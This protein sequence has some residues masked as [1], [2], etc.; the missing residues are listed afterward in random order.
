MFGL[1]LFQEPKLLTALQCTVC[2]RLIDFSEVDETRVEVQLFGAKKYSV[3]SCCGMENTDKS[4]G[5]K[6]RWTRYYNRTHTK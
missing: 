2:L 4:L 5:Y 3:C 6:Q 1:M